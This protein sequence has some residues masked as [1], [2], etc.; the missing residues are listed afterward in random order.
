[1]FRAEQPMASERDHLDT[2]LVCQERDARRFS[3]HPRAAVA[4]GDRPNYHSAVTMWL[5]NSLKEPL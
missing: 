3:A 1:M 5:D 4:P 2:E